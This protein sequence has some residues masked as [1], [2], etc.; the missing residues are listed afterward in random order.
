MGV[1]TPLFSRTISFPSDWLPTLAILAH[2]HMLSNSVALFTLPTLP[3]PLSIKSILVSYVY[4]LGGIACSIAGLWGV[5]HLVLYVIAFVGLGVI[6][7]TTSEV[8]RTGVSR[9]A[10]IATKEA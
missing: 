6:S 3:I 4:G 1:Q 9:S 7:Q 8:T 5:P 10:A 2:G